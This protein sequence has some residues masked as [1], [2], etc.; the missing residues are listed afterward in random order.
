MVLATDVYYKDDSAKAVGV[1]FNWEDENPTAIINTLI[2]KVENYIS[3]QFYKRELPCLLKL[4]EEIDLTTIKAIVVDGHV[5]VDNNLTPGLG[6][7]LYQAL[8]KQIPIIGVAKKAFHN[9][10]KVSFPIYRGLSKAP[11]YVSAIG[12]TP[13]EVI[14]AVLNMKGKYRI[15]DILKIVDQESRK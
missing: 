11:L 13:D 5:Y 6:G 14:S 15:P 7:H 8:N 3:G 2:P 9:T 12:I 1:V 10:E 4:L